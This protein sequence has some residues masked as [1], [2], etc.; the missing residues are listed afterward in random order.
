M[1]FS[2]HLPYHVCVKVT[3]NEVK[4]TKIRQEV[5]FHV[6]TLSTSFCRSAYVWCV[7]QQKTATL[8]SDHIMHLPCLYYIC[9]LYISRSKMTRVQLNWIRLHPQ[10][11]TF[12][13]RQVFSPSFALHLPHIC[14]FPQ[15]DWFFF[16]FTKLVPENDLTCGYKSWIES[17]ES[18]LW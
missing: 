1:H 15:F 13:H 6:W 4:T 14:L 8:K 12:W 9:V 3:N 18:D 16:F 10:N 2:R 11:I 5:G 7:E 17:T